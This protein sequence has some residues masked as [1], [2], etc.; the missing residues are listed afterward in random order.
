MILLLSINY[1]MFVLF[2][3]QGFLVHKIIFCCC[4]LKMFYVW[5]MYLLLQLI[6]VY[7]RLPPLLDCF[8]CAHWGIHYTTVQVTVIITVQSVGQEEQWLP[9]HTSVFCELDKCVFASLKNRPQNSIWDPVLWEGSN[10]NALSWCFRLCQSICMYSYPSCC[11]EQDSEQAA[12]P[13]RFTLWS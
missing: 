13:N 11:L 5:A 7:F 1:F 2:H 3:R 8:F 10:K 12:I 4:F 9:L 6:I